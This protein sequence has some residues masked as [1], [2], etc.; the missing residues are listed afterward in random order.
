[1]AIAAVISCEHLRE[2]DKKVGG[3]PLAYRAIHTMFF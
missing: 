1:M 3:R 2:R